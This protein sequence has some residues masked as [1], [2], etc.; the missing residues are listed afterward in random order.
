MKR[1]YGIDLLRMVL[2]LM[3]VVLHV[4]GQGGVLEASGTL[5]VKYGAS[6]LLESFA[7]C[8]VNCYAMITGYVYIHGRYR[9]SSLIQI[10][11]QALVYSLGIVVCTWILKPENFGVL[12]LIHFS[13]P[14]SSG[15]YWY[16]SAYV[17]LFILI[18]FLN[19]AIHA[20]P[21]KQIKFYLFLAL[22]I[23]TIPSAL[24]RYDAFALK[25]GYGTFW[26]A[27]MYVL[28][29]CM[30]KYGWWDTV[31][32]GKATLV[33][34][35][36]VLLSWGIK[37]GCESITMRLQGEA[38]SVFSV[39]TYTSPLMVVGAVALFLAFK[40]AA[41]SPKLTGLISAL[42]PAAFGVYLIHQ[43]DYIRG[44][45]IVDKF[46]FL[47]EYSMPLMVIGVLLSAVAIFVICLFIDWIRCKVFKWLRVKERLEKLEDKII[48][49]MASAEP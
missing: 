20:I 42:S 11:L 13:L 7:F 33:Y 8:A 22:F 21:E 41:V 48:H 34:I 45:F 26:L 37:I 27:L 32:P 30:R 17:G 31:K 18:P 9:F 44:F 47:A 2:M 4:L 39:M 15:V 23:F 46:A 16:L 3:V 43:H 49:P 28:G 40:N 1:N 12:K 14:V 35:C 5:T 25:W 6:W 36:S 38:N 24:T 10:W 19:A 29:A